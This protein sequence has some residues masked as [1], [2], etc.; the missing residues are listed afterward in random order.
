[1]DSTSGTR[2]GK[3]STLARKF[4][5]FTTLPFFKGFQPPEKMWKKLWNAKLFWI[6]SVDEMWS[7]WMKNAN[8]RRL[9]A[10]SRWWYLFY[11]YVVVIF[12]WPSDKH[13]R[14]LTVLLCFYSEPSKLNE[15]LYLSD[16]T[17]CLK[18]TTALRSC[19]TARLGFLAC[20]KTK[21]ISLIVKEAN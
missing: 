3:I 19:W 9:K 20:H 6:A 10:A 18:W 21:N 15:Q 16:F 7:N 11:A 1:M 8:E 13:L 5:W 17:K 14:Y 12:I 4:S 2:L